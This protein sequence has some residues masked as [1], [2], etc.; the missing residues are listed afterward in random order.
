MKSYQEMS[1]EE[2]LQ[3]KESLKAAYKEYQKMDLSLNMARGKPAV[4]QL[5]MV[6]DILDVLDSKSEMVTENGIDV[7]N[8]G[9]MDGIPEAKKLMADMMGTKAE[10]VL[11]FGNASLTIMYDTVSRSMTH[12]VCGST[13]WCHLDKIKFLCPVPGYDRHFAITEH[14]GI[15]MINI[16]MTE[17]GP[18]MDMVEQYV[19]NDP[20]VKGIWCVPKYSNPQGYVYSDETVKRFAAL[21]PAAEDFRIFW[22][23]AYGVHHLY[24]DRQVELLDIISECEKAGNPDI[25]YEFASTSKVTFAGAGIAAMAS[26]KKNLDFIRKSMTI[27][28][29]GYDKINQY[30]HV[31]YFKDLDGIKAKMKQHADILRPKFELVDEI[32]TKEL[33]GLGIGTWTK[34]LGG[35]FIAFETLEGCATSVVK[36]AKEAGVVLTG[37]GAPFPYGTD[38]RDFVIRI[39]PSYP[40]LEELRQAAEV[41]VLCVKLASVEKLLEA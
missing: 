32:L 5:D 19:N 2:L 28:T 25:V 27:Q 22:D 34:P 24:E 15:E 4:E 33:E 11:V 40:T 21:K 26:S 12:G 8:Y 13:P 23:N 6:M 20:S 17:D 16:P 1:K 29:I 31:K 37:A 30:R 38:P 9:E 41:F 10:N 7:R 3:E 36:K 35:Y 18:D 39:A 14:F